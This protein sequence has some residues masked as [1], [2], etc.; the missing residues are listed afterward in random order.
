MKRTPTG[1]PNPRAHSSASPTAT[2]TKDS[3]TQNRISISALVPISHTPQHT[4]LCSL[5]S[6]P[7]L[8]H[9]RMARKERDVYHSQFAASSSTMRQW[10]A[11][12]AT[13]PAG[14]TGSALLRRAIAIVC[15]E[16]SAVRARCR[17]STSPPYPAYQDPLAQSRRSCS[18]SKVSSRFLP[19][20]KQR[21]HTIVTFAHDGA[22]SAWR[23]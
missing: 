20:N 23:S 5:D 2:S 15:P 8:C 10:M 22:K 4:S 13:P 1:T 7:I 21:P 14:I 16:L 18:R 6:N 17:P 19:G 9:E 3:M 12:H 11:Q